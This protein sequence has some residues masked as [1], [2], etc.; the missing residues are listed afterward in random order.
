MRVLL[1]HAHDVA[2]DLTPQ[3]HIAV[4]RAA[5]DVVLIPGE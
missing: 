4:F 1:A 3:I 5:D 2:F